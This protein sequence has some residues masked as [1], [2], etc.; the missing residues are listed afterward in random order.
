MPTAGL[1]RAGFAPEPPLTRRVS[2]PSKLYA[3][4]TAAG[5]S[6]HRTLTA[7]CSI[8]SA[9]NCGAS[10]ARRLLR[11]PRF[12]LLWRSDRRGPHLRPPLGAASWWST[13]S[14]A[15]ASPSA[16]CSISATRWRGR[17]AS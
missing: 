10:D 3:I 8:W 12:F 5:D 9:D 14:S 1:G 6:R 15:A 13:S 16:C 4:L 17:N 2:R 11:Y 7:P